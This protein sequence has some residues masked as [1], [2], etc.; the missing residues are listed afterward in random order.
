VPRAIA[1]LKKAGYAGVW[2]IEYEGKEGSAGYAKCLER[3][4]KLV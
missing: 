3:L 4:K 1:A 2:C